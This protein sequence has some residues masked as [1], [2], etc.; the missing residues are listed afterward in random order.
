VVMQ[1]PYLGRKGIALFPCYT[2]T[3]QVNQ[4]PNESSKTRNF[5]KITK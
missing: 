1:H 5:K 2:H 3:I 4:R